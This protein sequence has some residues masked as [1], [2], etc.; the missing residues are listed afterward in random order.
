LNETLGAPSARCME[1]LFAAI[2]AEGERK[3]SRR[4]SFDLAGRISDF[5]SNFAPRTLAWSA[6]AA[7]LA[8]M[9][10][11]AVIT[12]VVVKE[13]GA[14][15]ETASSQTTQA[16]GPTAMVRFVAQASAS[17]IT[18]FLDAYKATVVDGPKA[19]GLFR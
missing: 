6:A 16:D 14:T 9:V 8:I 12:T 19:G 13:K 5:L 17:D 7:A 10:Q 4:G 2:E 11:A 1:R 15:Y 18:H 3:P